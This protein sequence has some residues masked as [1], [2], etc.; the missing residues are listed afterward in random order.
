MSNNVERRPRLAGLY[1]TLTLA[2]LTVGRVG[3][4]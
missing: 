2:L 1:M 4:R 3:A